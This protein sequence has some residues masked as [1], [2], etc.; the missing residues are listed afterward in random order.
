MP[1]VVSFLPASV[2]CFWRGSPLLTFRKRLPRRAFSTDIVTQ[3]STKIHSSSSIHPSAVIGK[4][5]D[6][7]PFSI[8]G[9]FAKIGDGTRLLGHCVVTGETDIGRNNIINPV[10]GTPLLSN[11]DERFCT[12]CIEPTQKSL[13]SS[14]SRLWILPADE[15][16]G[17]RGKCIHSLTTCPFPRMILVCDAHSSPCLVVTAAAAA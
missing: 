14:R 16:R 11:A 15:P 2:N 10:N 7:G 12:N 9:P 8:V 1:C 13:S 6:V 4:G 17:E 3:A 5:C